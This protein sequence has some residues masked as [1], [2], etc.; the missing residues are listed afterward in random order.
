MDYTYRNLKYDWMPDDVVDMRIDYATEAAL[1]RQYKA[2]LTRMAENPPMTSGGDHDSSDRWESSRDSSGYGNYT[3]IVEPTSSTNDHSFKKR[4]QKRRPKPKD[5]TVLICQICGDRALGYNFDAITCESCK[6][7]FRRNAL[8]TKVFT[9]SFEGSCKLDPHTRKFCSGCRLK[10]CMDVG[11]KKEWIL[12]DDQLAKRRKKSTRSSSGDEMKFHS[13][14]SQTTLTSPPQVSPSGVHG[15]YRPPHK[16]DMYSPTGSSSEGEVNSTNYMSDSTEN[17]NISS[18]LTSSYL[19]LSPSVVKTELNEDNYSR[20]IPPDVALEILQ[21]EKD[22]NSVFDSGY[23]DDQSRR[24]TE[25]PHNANDLFNMTDIFI[26]RLIKF[27]K[28]IPEF[29][30]LKQEDQIHLLKGGIMEIMV[31][32]SAMGFDPQNL[33]WK[34]REQQAKESG[35]IKLD[36]SIIKEH[37]GS[38]MYT[39]HIQF[40]KGL[41]QLTRSDRT[42]MTLMFVIEIFSPDRANLKNTE[43]VKQTQD[44][45]TRWLQLYLE[46]TMPIVEAERLYPELLKKMLEVRS[47]GD[48]SAKLASNLDI[49]KLE[50]LLIEVFNLQK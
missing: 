15:A 42:V 49:S 40:V 26:R 50:P 45:F 10:K 25:K 23:T 47:I 4:D 13:P 11:M 38:S 7:F 17:S 48:A 46:S 22:Y 32:R 9:C 37:L 21:L 44:K 6:A 28:H 19:T 31:L 2:L 39:D 41:H 1:T 3:Q 16:M 29:K 18:P 30:A 12:S 35:E 14:S 24:F 36:P 27:A 33:K 20:P 8:K 43:S 5:G 34:V